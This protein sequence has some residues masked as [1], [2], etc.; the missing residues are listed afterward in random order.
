MVGEVEQ[1]SQFE[2]QVMDELRARQVYTALTSSPPVLA[3][4][5][6]SGGD[7]GRPGSTVSIE[8]GGIVNAPSSE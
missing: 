6:H 1:I 5:S 3:S 8:V 7:E 2:Q 4:S